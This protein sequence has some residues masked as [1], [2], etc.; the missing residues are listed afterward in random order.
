MD[1]VLNHVRDITQNL[2]RGGARPLKPLRLL[3]LGSAGTGKTTTVQTA[4]Q[5]VLRHLQS[6]RLPLDFIRVAAPTGCS[7]F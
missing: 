4:L 6:L 2:A 1:I 5:E 3:L 7:A